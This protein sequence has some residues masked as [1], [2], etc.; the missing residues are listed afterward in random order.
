MAFLT[1]DWIALSLFSISSLRI[2]FSTQEVAAL[3]AEA[4]KDKE[5]VQD[6]GGILRQS[7]NERFKEHFKLCTSSTIFFSPRFGGHQWMVF[8]ADGD[9]SFSIPQQDMV[10][11]TLCSVRGRSFAIFK[12]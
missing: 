4:V 2:V 5:G 6:I 3:A 1:T 11:F 7:L 12:Y 9:L 10:E 8:V